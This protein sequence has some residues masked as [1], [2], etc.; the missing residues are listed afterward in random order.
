[1]TF[2]D[3]PPTPLS[4]DE[5]D[6][7]LPSTC[8]PTEDEDAAVRATPTPTPKHP[9]TLPPS[10]T[11]TLPHSTTPTHTRSMGGDSG[12]G[13]GV[14][15][16]SGGLGLGVGIAGVAAGIAAMVAATKKSRKS[17]S[18]SRSVSRNRTSRAGPGIKVSEELPPSQKNLFTSAALSF[19]SGI[20]LGSRRHGGKYW[21]NIASLA[22]G[23]G[24]GE[25]GRGKD[26][27]GN[28]VVYVKEL[29][30]KSSNWEVLGSMMSNCRIFLSA[31]IEGRP[32]EPGGGGSGGGGG[33][34]G[35]Q[36]MYAPPFA[37]FSV[38]KSETRATAERTDGHG[39]NPSDVDLSWLFLRK[40]RV[41]SHKSLLSPD[42]SEYDPLALDNPSQRTGT[43]RVLYQLPGLMI[44]VIPYV[45]PKDLK[46]QLNEQFRQRNEDL[47]PSLTLTLIRG[48]KRTMYQAGVEGN[49][50]LSTIAAAYVYLEKLILAGKVVADI[51]R[52][53]AAA[54]LYLAEKFNGV[55]LI[56][57]HELL[58]VLSSHFNVAPKYI[59]RAEFRVM[60]ELDFALH[61][62][63]H[64]VFPHLMLLAANAKRDITSF[65]P[66]SDFQLSFLRSFYSSLPA[67]LAQPQF[68]DDFGEGGGDDDDE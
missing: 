15:V 6:L 59:I 50:D 36:E 47:H 58:S 44:S 54:C 3:I 41:A 17:G 51:A 20:A 12:A 25:E 57:Y 26:R 42:A 4:D 8:E 55:K 40:K 65:G 19:L 49:V 60:I 43:E 48:I 53:L 9:P 2:A 35:G 34:K 30:K 23:T 32:I 38:I 39:V 27:V 22:E 29:Q 52:L 24:G 10:T 21:G 63:L 68:D 56:D 5:S 28:N 64:Q 18:R 66:F 13:V 11:P 62:D 46:R 7:S 16:R 61:V 37:L 31:P 45:S 67:E 33:G 14:G 1:M